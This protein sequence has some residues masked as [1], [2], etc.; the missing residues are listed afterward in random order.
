MSNAEPR[1]LSEREFDALL[2]ERI[3]ASLKMSLAEFI[4]ALKNGQLDPD[5]SRVAGLAILVGA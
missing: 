2:E 3:Q 5:S 1:E 4:L